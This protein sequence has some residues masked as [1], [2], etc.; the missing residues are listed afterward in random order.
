MKAW[1]A[2]DYGPPEKLRFG[3]LDA[4]VPK[5]GQIL[6]RV[7]A[8]AANPFDVKMTSGNLKEQ[9]PLRFP[10]VPGMDGAGVV[11]SVGPGVTEYK[12]GDAVFGLF[13]TGGTFGEL[14]TITANDPRLARKSEG[15]DFERAAA[16][17]EAALTALTLLRA[18][19]VHTDQQILI[20]GAT[21]GIGLYAIQLARARGA[22]IIAT[23]QP[24]DAA[25][26]RTLGAEEVVDYRKH[27][28]VKD[29]RE[30]YPDGLD[31]VIDLIDT[32]EKLL[33]IA[34]VI[35][36]DGT[37]ASPL[38]GPEQSAFPEDVN[39]RYIQM[40]PH[41]GDLDDLG[42]RAA[43]GELRVEI[44]ETYPFEEAKQ[45]L[46][47]LVDPHKHTRGKLVATIT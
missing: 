15:L 5:D 36:R 2:D 8:A 1:I 19:D 7:R 41:L 38:F 21:G 29:V 26:L 4:P 12:P 44:G 31:A 10:Y 24:E 42:R 40:D 14:A 37:L 47:D 34:T 20:I 6:V 39:V 46:V 28:V 43:S 35:R 3:E 32:G 18:A 13:R 25:Y 16:I 17:P 11:E 27:D 30:R 23:G 9:L 33:P 22:R 45:A